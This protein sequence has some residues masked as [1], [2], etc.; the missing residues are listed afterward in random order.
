MDKL[1]EFA[2][3]VLKELQKQQEED[4]RYYERKALRLRATS[5]AFSTL[6]PVLEEMMKPPKFPK[7]KKGGPVYV[8]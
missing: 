2:K 4:A 5:K 1:W 3:D 7:R 8:I 6:L